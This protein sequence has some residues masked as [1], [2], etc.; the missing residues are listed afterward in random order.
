MTSLRLGIFNG[1]RMSSKLD[2]DRCKATFYA[3]EHHLGN[4]VVG[5]LIVRVCLPRAA[6]CII[7]IA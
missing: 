2:N 6:L 4:R 7:V 1:H 5:C 3:G